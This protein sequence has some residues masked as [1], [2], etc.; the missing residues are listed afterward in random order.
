MSLVVQLKAYFD[1]RRIIL[2]IL[3]SIL[4]ALAMTAVS[5]R[6]YDMDYVSRLDVSL[7]S[8]EDLRTKTSTGDNTDKFDSIGPLDAQTFSDF[9]SIYTK[10]RAALNA[11]GK[12]DGDSLSNDSLRVGSNE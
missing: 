7:P 5:L 4:I 10:N 12:F 3:F 8:R 1:H 6:L 11:T 9:Q 2:V